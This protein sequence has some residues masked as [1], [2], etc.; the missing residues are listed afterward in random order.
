MNIRKHLFNVIVIEQWYRLPRKFV[1]FPSL[2]I[3]NPQLN[4]V[5]G[6]LL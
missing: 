4:T 2:K 5:Q 3:L 6:N 1:E